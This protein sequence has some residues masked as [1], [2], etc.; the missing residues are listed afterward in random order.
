MI[1]PPMWWYSGLL[2]LALTGADARGFLLRQHEMTAGAGLG[3]PLRHV[4]QGLL[5]RR[6]VQAGAGDGLPDYFP[7]AP[8]EGVHLAAGLVFSSS[9]LASAKQTRQPLEL[10]TV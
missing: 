3:E 8:G 9:S 2:H 10:I 6:R 5:Q 7:I 4:R 1:D